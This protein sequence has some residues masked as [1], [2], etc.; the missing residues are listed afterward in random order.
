M[1]RQTKPDPYNGFKDDRERRR[2]L[3]MRVICGAIA[4]IGA[5][6]NEHLRGLLQWLM[7]RL[8]S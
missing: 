8:T 3:N 6:N 1:P 2:A 5:A 7:Q 4:V